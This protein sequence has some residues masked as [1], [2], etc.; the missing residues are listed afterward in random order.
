MADEEQKLAAYI[1]YKADI[2]YSYKLAMQCMPFDYAHSLGKVVP[3][4]EQLSNYWCYGFLK[5]RPELKVVKPQTL[6]ISRPNSA[7]SEVL[8]EYILYK[9]W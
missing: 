1:S 8:S 5:R 2:G 3:A 4:T 7:S 6:A 9:T